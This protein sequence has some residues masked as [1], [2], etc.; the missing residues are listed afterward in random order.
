MANDDHSACIKHLRALGNRLPLAWHQAPQV[1]A[2]KVGAHLDHRLE[3]HG[4]ASQIQPASAVWIEL[5]VPNHPDGT[6][7]Q[8]V[9]LRARVADARRCLGPRGILEEARTN[10]P[11]RSTLPASVATGWL[12]SGAAVTERPG[13]ASRSASSRLA[14]QP[15]RAVASAAHPSRCARAGC[16]RR[17]SHRAERR[18]RIAARKQTCRGWAR[19]CCRAHRN[20]LACDPPGR[21]GR[22][23]TASSLRC[24]GSSGAERRPLEE[25]EC[26]RARAEPRH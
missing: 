8:V 23:R 13:K 18:Q 24:S 3:D 21:G 25:L 26:S 1:G 17:N 16:A 19:A 15:S 22:K 20:R 2:V 10:V 6:Y 12:R 4:A 5:G 9:L 14:A 7:G 11:L